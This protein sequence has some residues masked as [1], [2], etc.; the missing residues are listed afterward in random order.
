MQRQP[1]N[2]MSRVSSKSISSASWPPSFGARQRALA[3]F[4]PGTFGCRGT[5]QELLYGNALSA[6]PFLTCHFASTRFSACRSISAACKP[7]GHWC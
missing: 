3:P 5:I 7:R 2:S 4:R 6:Q 1:D